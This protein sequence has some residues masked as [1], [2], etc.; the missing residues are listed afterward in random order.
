MPEKVLIAGGSGAIGKHLTMYFKQ[1]GLEISIL[2]RSKRN[3][4]DIKTFYWDIA[5]NKID[6][7][8]FDGISHII[9]LSGA[10]ISEKRWT[11]ERR[12]EIV[13]SRIN[14]TNLLFQ[15][16]KSNNIKLKSFISASAIGYYGAVTNEHLYSEND[17]PGNDFL[18]RTC[19]QWEEAADQFANTGIRTV[20]IRTGIVL[21]RSHGVLAKLMLPAKL[22]LCAALGS[23]NQYFPW[24]HIDDLCG[25]YYKAIRDKT[26][27]GSYNAVAPATT[28]NN[29]FIETLCHVLDKPK[30]IPN[31]PSIF[32]KIAFGD[33]AD[34][35]LNGSRISAEKIL[36]SGYTFQ[37]DD[38]GEAINNLVKVNK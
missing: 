9:Q 34:S 30:I 25:I 28:T 14:S 36:K 1:K 35:L 38:L 18:A 2:S 23:G 17:L 15:S 26:M 24:I 29:Q 6:I 12:M 31:I 13:N 16:I 7:N 37:F 4:E 20:K 22:S 10:N 33:L 3:L 11:N 19:T 32:L 21:I 8:C 5:N 27:N